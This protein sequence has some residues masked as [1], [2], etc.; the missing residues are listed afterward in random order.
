MQEGKLAAEIR[1]L[2]ETG[3]QPRNTP[4]EGCYTKDELRI[5]LKMSES[6]LA[7]YLAMGIEQGTIR[8]DRGTRKTKQGCLRAVA[9]YAKAGD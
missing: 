9:V 2:A 8:K 6:R 3:E 7:R 4:A 5:L 1:R